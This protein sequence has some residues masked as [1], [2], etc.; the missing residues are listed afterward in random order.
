[1]PYLGDTGYLAVKPQASAGVAVLP[2]TF[3]PLQSESVTFDPN[4]TADRRM[5]GIA[6]ESDDLLRGSYTVSG[7]IVALADVEALGHLL[8]MTYAK[9]TTTGDAT[10]G[11]T[12]AFTPGEGD[13]YTLE[14][15]MG[16]Y[17]RRIFGAKGA[18]LSI[19]NDDGRLSSTVNIVA[20][21]QFMSGTLKDALTGAVTSLEFDDDEVKNPAYGLAVGD[22]L[23]IGSVEVVITVITGNV[24]SFSSTSITASAG[25]A[26]YLKAQAPDLTSY[27]PLSM[28]STLV[29]TGDDETA[30]TTA[31]GSRTTATPCYDLTLTLDN[32]KLSAPATGYCGPATILN[33]TLSASLDAKRLYESPEQAH[34]FRS[35]IATA[36]TII[37][38]GQ[39]IGDGAEGLTV[40]LYRTKT[41]D[42]SDTLTMGDFIHDELTATALY[43]SDTA[44]TVEISLTNRTAG[45]AY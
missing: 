11:Y 17:A 2:D 20:M 3:I 9:G 12:H 33:G 8:N 31:A 35:R 43:D 25:D 41:T 16:D 44:K 15:G 26:V 34:N 7:D 40:K 5:K 36:Y 13:Y 45:T 23:V 28:C 27:V 4:L 42:L 37:S 39:A 38:T 1:M 14:I 18:S 21:G 19:T 24:I 30:A 6:W 10:D 22:T 32:G 29:G